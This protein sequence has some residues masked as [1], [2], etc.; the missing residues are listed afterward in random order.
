MA[1]SRQVWDRLYS[2]SAS[3]SA[4]ASSSIQLNKTRVPTSQKIKVST[5]P[6]FVNDTTKHMKRQPQPL[7]LHPSLKPIN[8][9]ENKIPISTQKETENIPYPT[10]EQSEAFK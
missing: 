4:I 9:N 5:T 6:S 1:F 10:K 8:E 3:A 2:A 7:K